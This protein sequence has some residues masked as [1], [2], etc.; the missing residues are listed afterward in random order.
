MTSSLPFDR[1]RT[2]FLFG[3]IE[4]LLSQSQGLLTQGGI[5][6]LVDTIVD[7]R[8]V[9]S[10]TET[11]STAQISWLDEISYSSDHYFIF[12]RPKITTNY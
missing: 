2:E 6:E 11:I 5:L 9:V 3:E 4:C 7:M 10:E 8:P 1:I 12:I